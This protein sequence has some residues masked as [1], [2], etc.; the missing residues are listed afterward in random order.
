M[1]LQPSLRYKSPPRSLTHPH[2][3]FYTNT[4]KQ[5]MSPFCL[6]AYHSSSLTDSPH[7]RSSPLPPLH[8]TSLLPHA[9]AIPSIPPTVL[10]VHEEALRI[11]ESKKTSSTDPA[12]ADT[13]TPAPVPTEAAGVESANVPVPNTGLA[14]EGKPS[15]T[16]TA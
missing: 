1:S 16:S 2:A 12:S 5:G 9:T 13:T 7:P 6:M 4:S 15:G 3:A 14:Q 11:K 10:D 8:P